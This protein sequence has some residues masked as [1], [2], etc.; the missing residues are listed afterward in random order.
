MA[1]PAGCCDR[2]TNGALMCPTRICVL[3]DR[4]D[5]SKALSSP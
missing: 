4:F 3:H 1:C 5:P 2:L